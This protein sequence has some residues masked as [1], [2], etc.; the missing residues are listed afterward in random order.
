[1]LAIAL[2]ILAAAGLSPLPE[3]TAMVVGELAL[4]GEL[5]PVRGV[6]PIALK[7]RKGGFDRMIVPEHN[8]SEGALVQGIRVYGARTVIEAAE[9]FCGT[10]TRAPAVAPRDVAPVSPLDLADVRGQQTA[11][12]ALEVAAAGGHN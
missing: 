5:L 12:W 8:A 10:S 7:A 2:G 1:D 3:R 9:I 6:L 4:S 11:K